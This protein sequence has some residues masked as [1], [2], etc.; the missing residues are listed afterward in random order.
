MGRP[1]MLYTVGLGPGDPELMTLKAARIIAAAP[2]IAF[3]AKRGR[4]GLARTVAEGRI[5]EDAEELRL[6]YPFTTE[7]AVDDPRYVAELGAFYEASAARIA[8]RLDAARDVALLCE[9]DPFFYGSSLAMLDRLARHYPSEVVPGVT[10]MS[11]CWTRAGARMTH[12]DD[13]LTVLPGTLDEDR[14]V[15]RLDRGDAAVIMKVGRHLPKIVAALRRA[16]LAER[17]IYVERGTMPGE[18]IVPVLEME[19]RSAPYFSLVLVPGRQRAR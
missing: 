16:G 9:G 14:L 17:A 11:G 2:V 15:A 5:R 1:G 12:G 19:D 10:G 8:E 6:D 7:I 18:R 4:A 3:F 13:V